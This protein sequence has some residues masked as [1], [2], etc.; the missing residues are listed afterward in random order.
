METV[1]GRT[2]RTRSED[3]G[4]VFAPCIPPAR[5]SGVC[6]RWSC[7]GAGSERSKGVPSQRDGEAGV[8]DASQGAGWCLSLSLFCFLGNLPL[9]PKSLTDA[10]NSL[11]D[12]C[13]VCTFSLT[14]LIL[15]SV[16]STEEF[17]DD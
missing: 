13:R 1:S 14:S 2:P 3:K 9:F 12:D 10:P 5:G 7:T 8:A 11:T 6:A 4:R 15:S 16:L 17:K